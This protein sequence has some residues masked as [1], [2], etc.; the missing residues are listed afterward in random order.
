MS[1]ICY[2]FSHSL[3][4]L[5]SI[6]YANSAAWRKCLSCL[7]G[8]YSFGLRCNLFDG[9]IRTMTLKRLGRIHSLIIFIEFIF[10]KHARFL[11]FISLALWLLAKWS[12]TW[13]QV[14]NMTFYLTGNF[15]ILS[16]PHDIRLSSTYSLRSAILFSPNS[17]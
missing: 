12:V 10:M 7:T 17:N 5:T 13:I 11:L 2:W 6:G 1:A 3:H 14:V 16:I 15:P 4:R 8:F 9:F